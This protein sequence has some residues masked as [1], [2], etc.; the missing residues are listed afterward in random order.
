[1]QNI[2]LLLQ[3]E[4]PLAFMQVVAYG[5]TIAISY[6]MLYTT[7]YRRQINYEDIR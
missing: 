1:M 6:Y 7:M 5:L 3:P 4:L 2:I